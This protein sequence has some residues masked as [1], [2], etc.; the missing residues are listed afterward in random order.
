MK[1]IEEM[2]KRA[3]NRSKMPKEPATKKRMKKLEDGTTI[4]PRK[5]RKKLR[6]CSVC[7]RFGPSGLNCV[8]GSGNT[9]LC[10]KF[11]LSGEPKCQRCLQF[12]HKKEKTNCGSANPSLCKNFLLDGKNK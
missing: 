6:Q 4:L 1:R 3:D 11:E 7:L 9:E 5:R 10:K 12:R 2:L 8:T